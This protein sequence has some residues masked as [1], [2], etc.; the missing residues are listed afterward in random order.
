MNDFIL[1]IY[2]QTKRNQKMKAIA[3]FLEDK[4]ESE[5]II[6]TREQILHYI[7]KKDLWHG[8]GEPLIFKMLSG[9]YFIPK[10]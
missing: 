4:K 8:E 5:G 6:A 7:M 9:D 10:K 1:S 3:D 2:H